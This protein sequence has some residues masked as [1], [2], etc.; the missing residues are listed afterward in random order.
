MVNW[1]PI[2]FAAGSGVILGFLSTL[3]LRN[4]GFGVTVSLVVGFLGGFLGLFLFPSAD[5]AVI[6][7]LEATLR[8]LSGALLFLVASKLKRRSRRSTTP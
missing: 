4:R 8:G 3:V 1:W 7:P 6:G 5:H 2:V